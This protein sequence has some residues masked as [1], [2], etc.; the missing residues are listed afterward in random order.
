MGGAL[1][2]HPDQQLREIQVHAAMQGILSYL[3]LHPNSADCLRGVQLWL[4]IL[5][6]Q[7]T[8]EIVRLALE[9]L[10]QRGQVEAKSLPG[11]ATV[12]GRGR[13]WRD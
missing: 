10:M 4:R 8:E 7:L 3:R 2:N 13:R 6:D 12:Y 9:R 11:G 5:P 1:G